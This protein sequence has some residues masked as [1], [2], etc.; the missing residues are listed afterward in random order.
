MNPELRTGRFN[1]A[2]KQV[3]SAAEMFLII[4]AWLPRTEKSMNSDGVNTELQRVESLRH[5][6]FN[7]GARIGIKIGPEPIRFPIHE[8]KSV[9]I[10]E[11]QID[12]AFHE[13]AH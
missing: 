2:Q 13:T 9:F 11:H 8:V 4:I 1:P 12:K 6:C 10:L 3:I 5:L 7:C